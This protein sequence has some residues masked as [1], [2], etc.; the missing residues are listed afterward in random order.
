[1]TALHWAARQGHKSRALLLLD[2]GTKD[3]TRGMTALHEA[4]RKD[5]RS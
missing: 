5:A 1:M 4:A 2:Y 3:D